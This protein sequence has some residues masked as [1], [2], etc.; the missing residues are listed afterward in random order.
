MSSFHRGGGTLFCAALGDSGRNGDMSAAISHLIHIFSPCLEPFP[1]HQL[2]LQINVDVLQL[3]CLLRWEKNS[4]DSF[5]AGPAMRGTI[6][7]VLRL[8]ASSHPI[9]LVAALYLAFA[10]AQGRRCDL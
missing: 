10:Y 4:A 8:P 7:Q 9:L 5:S 2:D 3:I 6:L 1:A